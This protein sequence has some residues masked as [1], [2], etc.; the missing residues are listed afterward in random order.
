MCFFCE[1]HKC[2]SD[3]FDNLPN[4]H[5]NYHHLQNAINYKTLVNCNCAVKEMVH[6]VFKQSAPKTNRKNIELNLLKW[7]NTLRA[8]Q[9]IM[10]GGKDSSLVDR[11]D[12]FRDSFHC[13]ITDPWLHSLLTGW[14]ITEDLY[15]EEDLSEKG[16]YRFNF[17]TFDFVT[18]K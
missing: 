17:S 11:N 4:L 5:I 3:N 12:N 7:T 1:F 9:F 16:E 14:Y 6:R 10:E 13:L 8:I 2:F 15:P 18:L